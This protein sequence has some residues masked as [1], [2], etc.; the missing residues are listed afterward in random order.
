MK[1]I[2][3]LKKIIYNYYPK[4]INSMRESELYNNSKEFKLLKEKISSRKIESKIEKVKNKISSLGINEL[5]DFSLFDWYDRSYNLQF[6]INEEKDTVHIFCLNISVIAN[7]YTY[8]VL[9]VKKD[10]NQ[11]LGTFP[12]RSIR[13]SDYN[14]NPDMVRKI[15]SIIEENLEYKKISNELLNEVII[16]INFQDISMGDFNVFNAF[17][18]NNLYTQF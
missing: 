1:N 12:K 14:Y 7:F 8:Y 17:F 18:L 2:V 5:F 13:L 16:D 6:L 3:G 4:G 11:V 9:E 15:T 10:F